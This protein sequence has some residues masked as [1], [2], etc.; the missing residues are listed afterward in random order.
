MRQIFF[1]LLLCLPTNRAVC[2]EALFYLHIMDKERIVSYN[3]GIPIFDDPNINAIFDKYSVTNFSKA[4]PLSGY[5]Y[6]R[7]IYQITADSVGL[8]QELVEFD[9]G[10]FPSYQ[11]I[12]DNVPIGSY[13]PNDWTGHWPNDTAALAFIKAPEAWDICKGDSNIIIGVTDTYFD[14]DHEDMQ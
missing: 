2:Q 6:L 12:E 1:I 11:Q 4:F 5:D 3:E 14:L 9:N 7:K 10:L 8:A 13:Y